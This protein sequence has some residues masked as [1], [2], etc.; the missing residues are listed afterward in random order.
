MRSQI[1][2]HQNTQDSE[3]S[4]EESQ[5]ER[6]CRD[7]GLKMT[8]QRQVIARILSQTDGHPDAAELHQMAVK[9]NPKISLTTVYRTVK[10]LEDHGILER[11]DLGGDRA[12]YEASHHGVHYHLLNSETDEVLEFDNAKLTQLLHTIVERMGFN[13]LSHRVE[14]IGTPLSEEDE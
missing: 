13:L 1:D 7:A 9:E 11:L 2:P 8:G 3:E 5:L 10:L 14:L 12:R 4:Q 6:H